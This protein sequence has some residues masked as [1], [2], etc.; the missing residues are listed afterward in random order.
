MFN[1]LIS[2][3][4]P[5]SFQTDTSHTPPNLPPISSLT[6]DINPDSIHASHSGRKIYSQI[7]L[8]SL[9]TTSSEVLTIERTQRLLAV[10]SSSLANLDGGVSTF[11][12]NLSTANARGSIRQRQI[13]NNFCTV[14]RLGPIQVEPTVRLFGKYRSIKNLYCKR[15]AATRLKNFRRYHF[16]QR[17][18]Y[19]HPLS[20]SKQYPYC[21]RQQLVKLINGP[22]NESVHHCFVSDIDQNSHKSLHLA[23]TSTCK[24]LAFYLQI[25]IPVWKMVYLVAVEIYL[26][27][28]VIPTLHSQYPINK[29]IIR[30]FL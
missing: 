18:N 21:R 22:Q 25:K 4:S 3:T 9:Y 26:H 29:I 7:L 19:S 20:I 2:P 28:I 6:T 14:V 12:Q 30:F 11:F 24:V 8:L 13:G 17:S 27:Y 1:T 15:P 16:G 10:Q 5:D 23:Q